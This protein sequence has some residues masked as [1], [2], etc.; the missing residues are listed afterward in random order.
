MR[1][2]SKLLLSLLYHKLIRGAIATLHKNPASVYTILMIKEPIDQDITELQTG[3]LGG[4]L[5][6]NTL[7]TQHDSK[8]RAFTK[9]VVLWG[10]FG[11]FIVALIAIWYLSMRPAQTPSYQNDSKASVTATP[12]PSAAQTNTKRR[13][14]VLETINVKAA[15]PDSWQVDTETYKDNKECMK[16]DSAEFEI[17]YPIWQSGESVYSGVVAGSKPGIGVLSVTIC[18]SGEPQYPQVMVFPGTKTFPLATDIIMKVD[19][20]DEPAQKV[21]RVINGIV[22]ETKAAGSEGKDFMYGYAVAKGREYVVAEGS[23]ER[24]VN[25]ISGKNF[26]EGVADPTMKG[27]VILVSIVVHDVD[28]VSYQAMADDVYASSAFAEAL[29]I[30]NTLQSYK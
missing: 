6:A 22:L 8:Q 30:I 27:A 4:N 24:A 3:G 2:P 23:S 14:Y 20:F 16:L 28:T 10:I 5:T 1:S 25:P 15:L 18:G 21:D 13:G 19:S 26:N 11:I 17:R 12:V 29:E 7:S 9:Q